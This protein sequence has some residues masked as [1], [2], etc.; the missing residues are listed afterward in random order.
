MSVACLISGREFPRLKASSILV[1]DHGLCAVV[2]CGSRDD[3]DTLLRNLNLRGISSSRIEL[4]FLTHLHFDHCEN[5]DIFDNAT[6]V[7]HGEELELLE[8]LLK[9]QTTEGASRL[10]LQSYETLPPFYLRTILRKLHLY[11]SEYARLLS[12]RA[13]MQ[14]I[15]NDRSTINGFEVIATKGHSAG[16]ISVVV[17]GAQP[18]L[19][20]GDAVPSRRAWQ[21]RHTSNSQFC[22]RNREH[23]QS[24]DAISTWCGIVIPGHD[25][26]FDIQTGESVP[27]SELE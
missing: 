13:R 6:I 22:W 5:A 7:L 23:R 15:W 25:V 16:H 21:A 9:E 18:V 24:Q 4:L 19:I 8:R 20:A 3:R 14:I 10:L 17:S 2:D 1:E 12:D 26:P 11:R 27:Y